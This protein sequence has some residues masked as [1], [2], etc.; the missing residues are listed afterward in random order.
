MD[1]FCK[2]VRAGEVTPT[3]L[4]RSTWTNGQWRTVD[5]LRSFHKN[6]PAQH[7]KGK[8]LLEQLQREE[9]QRKIS[10]DFS[11]L[12]HAYTYGELIEESLNLLPIDKPQTDSLGQSRFF[13]LPSFLPEC[14]CTLTFKDTAVEI[15]ATCGKSSVWDS[16][17]QEACR[18]ANDGVGE[19]TK[20]VPFAPSQVARS[21]MV[22]PYRK[23]PSLLRSWDHF[24]PR[25]SKMQSCATH[26]LDGT[27][28][29]HKMIFHGELVDVQWLNPDNNAHAEQV[30]VIQAYR[31]LIEKAG[32]RSF[33][34]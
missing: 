1:A 16:L 22:L 4:F 30:A 28:Y 3:A 11:R 25:V 15:D 6:S 9:Q 20:P 23:M 29:R 13:W 17:P 18:T 2:M 8:K 34:K 31:S 33:S 7:P 14:I 32:V 19:M 24:A 12:F 5:N 26:T 10:D 27:V 21:S